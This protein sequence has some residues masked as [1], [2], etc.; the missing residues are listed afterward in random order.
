MIPYVT[1]SIPLCA[2]YFNVNIT[3][4][5]SVVDGDAS[6]FANYPCCLQ[7]LAQDFTFTFP[8]LF[9]KTLSNPGPFPYYQWLS[10]WNLTGKSPLGCT[11]AVDL[12]TLH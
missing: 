7:P 5:G 11:Y 1:A 12:T 6:Y 3:V 2:F 8:S 9:K 10:Y 4:S